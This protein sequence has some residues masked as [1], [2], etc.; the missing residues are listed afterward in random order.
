MGANAARGCFGVRRRNL[1]RG[2][3]GMRIGCAGLSA[4]RRRDSVPTIREKRRLIKTE[5]EKSPFW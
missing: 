1:E 4:G 3:P 5:L 2:V